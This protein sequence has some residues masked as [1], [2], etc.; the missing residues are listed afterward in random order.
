M[1]LRRSGHPR[2]IRDFASRGRPRFAFIGETEF[3]KEK[4]HFQAED[5]STKESERL[6]S[7]RQPGYPPGPV[8]LRHRIP[9]ALPFRESFLFRIV[10]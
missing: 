4:T 8:A 5:G 3:Q 1:S 2:G 7:L 9:P 6:L 10:Y